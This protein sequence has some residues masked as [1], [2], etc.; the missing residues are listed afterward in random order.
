MSNDA[1]PLIQDR[2]EMNVIFIHSELDDYGLTPA[3]FRVYAHLSRR[4]GKDGAYPGIDS[5]AAICCLSKPTVIT[6]IRRLEEMGML[7]VKRIDGQRNRYYL[8]KPSKW[9]GRRL[10][11]GNGTGTETSKKEVTGGSKVD[12]GTS[13]NGVTE[14]HPVEGDTS[15]VQQ[16]T[17]FPKVT[18]DR[19]CQ[20]LSGQPGFD[21]EWKA[22]KLH[23]KKLRAPMTERAEELILETLAERPHDAVEAL[24]VA[25]KKGWR[26]F[27]WDWYD[28]YKARDGKGKAA[29]GTD[30]A[31]LTKDNAV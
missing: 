10:K 22:F 20:F 29:S 23:R 17:L 27:E 21:E 15:K 1:E 30:Y 16:S 26:G 13:K 3:E 6:A 14:G 8:T 7:R 31:A 11:P 19:N 18:A 24:R 2:S 9:H 25:Q 28:K 4:A 12:N 5:M